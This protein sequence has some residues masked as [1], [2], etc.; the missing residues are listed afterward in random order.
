MPQQD[1]NYV[2]FMSYNPE[3]DSMEKVCRVYLTKGKLFYE[4]EQAEDIKKLVDNHDL[5][6]HFAKMGPYSVLSMLSKVF[7]GGYFHATMV[8][9]PYAEAEPKPDD[10]TEPSGA[11]EGEQAP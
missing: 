9:E 8:K 1:H 7:S 3:S 6:K 10:G 11:P 5:L 2:D 4:G